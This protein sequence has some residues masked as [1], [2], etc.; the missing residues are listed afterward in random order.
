MSCWD[1][2]NITPNERLRL[3]H[4]WSGWLHQAMILAAVSWLQ[5]PNLYLT[6]SHKFLAR[7]RTM[8]V[9]IY[10]SCADIDDNI[11][12]ILGCMWKGRTTSWDAVPMICQWFWPLLAKRAHSSI[13]CSMDDGFGCLNGLK[14][15]ITYNAPARIKNHA[16]AIL[17]AFLLSSW[18]DA[19]HQSERLRKQ[20]NDADQLNWYWK[21]IIELG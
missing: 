8:F 16:Y 5:R 10:Y 19:I 6:P 21:L 20:S 9:M 17:E 12:C 3:F 15:C 18:D 7:V 11:S 14:R 2:A 13:R 1:D 4:L